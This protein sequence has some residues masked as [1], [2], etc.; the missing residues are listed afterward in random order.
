VKT[1]VVRVAAGAFLATGILL[2]LMLAF[3]GR[4]GSFVGVYELVLGAM[5]VA[6]IVASLRAL[7]PK[8]WDARS[9]FDHRGRK[10]TPPEPIAELER[11]DRLLVLG[12]SN[13]FDVHYRL[14]PL[15]RG[16]ASERL[17]ARHGV[18]LDRDPEQARSLLGDELW[19]VVRP[20]RELD[21]RSGP[22][23]P[24][25]DVERLVTTLEEL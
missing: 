15:L 9:P 14:R 4:R 12:S 2:A 13:S 20:D 23:L 22:G 19:D 8:G 3:P 16:L 25:P 18:E 24:L 5:A 10:P 11:I 1:I 21:Q 7:E 17:H 6:A